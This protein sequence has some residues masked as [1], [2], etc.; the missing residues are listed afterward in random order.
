[1]SIMDRK[2]EIL[3]ILKK[4]NKPVSASSFAKQFGVSRQ[5]V[6][7]DVALLRAAGY[8]ILAT[9]RGYILKK[10]DT[11][12]PYVGTIVCKHTFE[13]MRQELY[14]IVDSGGVVIDVTI[15][16]SIYGQIVGQLNL[17]SKE[18]VDLFIKSV[19]G[20]LNKPLSVISG[21][22]HLHK[23]GCDSEEIFEVI[24]NKLIEMNIICS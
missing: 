9:P 1:M 14:T 6:V 18:D 13:E 22:I 3:K 5:I 8:D 16:H 11:I 15:E 4:V 19:S 17:S 7:G 23:I 10:E 2:K 20:N 24:K 21:G 12:F